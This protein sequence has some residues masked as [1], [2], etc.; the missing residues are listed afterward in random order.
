MDDST[1]DATPS[2]DAP[3][4]RSHRRAVTVAIVVGALILGGLAA[5]VYNGP[6]LS[7]GGPGIGGYTQEQVPYTLTTISVCLDQSGTATINDMSPV[8]EQGSITV[9][10]YAVRPLASNVMGMRPGEL[11]TFGFRSSGP[12]HVS[13]TCGGR[14]DEIG[15]QLVRT[16]HTTGVLDGVTIHYESNGVN[17][18]Y[19]L[20]MRIAMCAPGDKQDVCPVPFD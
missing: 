2:G 7:G 8:M 10:A 1:S 5:L 14:E 16:S 3:P 20:P 17:H 12:Q 13:L 18:T 6:R 15:F 9:Q 19:T 4:A 11:A